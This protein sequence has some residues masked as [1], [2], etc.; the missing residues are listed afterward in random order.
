MWLNVNRLLVMTICALAAFSSIQSRALYDRG[1][2]G[3]RSS[4]ALA[5]AHC[6]ASHEIGKL[7]LAVN[8]NGTFATGFTEATL[9]D[10]FTGGQLRS[11]EFP[12]RS[13]TTYCFAAAFWIGAVIGRDTLVSQGADGWL[14]GQEFRPDESPIGDM[15]KRS[16]IDPTKKEFDGAISEED[17]ISVYTDT[18]LQGVVNDPVRG[19]HKPLF[20]EVTERSFAWSYSYAEDL[21]LFDFS[22]KNIGI[23]KIEDA[24]MGIY[25]DADVFHSTK[26]LDG[27]TDD[28]CGFKEVFPQTIG[29]CDYFDTVNLAWIADNNGDPTAGAFDDQ[30][31]PAVTA[32]RIVRTPSK[33]LDVSF[34]W[35]ISNGAPDLD[36]G[37]REQPG[38][39][40]LKEQF[41]DIG[42]GG[43]GT[44]NGDVNKYYFLRNREFDYDQIYT[45]SILPSDTLWMLPDQEQ[46]PDFTDGYDTRYLLSFGP[47]DID[48]GQDLPISLAYVAGEKFHRNPNNLANLP[49]NP[50]LFYSYLD[51]TD[52]AY[53]A[54]WASW[55][56]DTPGLDT[57][58]DSYKGDYLICVND[59]V[60]NPDSSITI[61]DADTL[62]I[63]GDGVPDFQGASP[64]PAPTLRLIAERGQITV[65]FNGL[66]SETTRDV[67]SNKFDFEG[68]RVHYARD[69][70][71]ASYS[72]LSSYDL[73][74][75]N[76]YV[77]SDQ[78]G[79]FVLLDVPFTLDAL[80]DLYGD[81][82]AP[83]EY[84]R[85][86]PYV[87]PLHA[88]SI[89]YF[90][91]QDFNSSDYRN[92]NAIHKVWPDQP[93]PSSLI[94]DSADSTELTPEG[95]L[96]YFEYEFVIK[97]LLESVPYWVN[98]TA[99]DYGSPVSGL[100]SLETSR[101]VGAKIAF[102]QRS[103]AD[104]NANKPPVYV[105]PNP[106]RG[107][108]NYN[109][110]G[111]EG[112]ASDKAEDYA[113]VINFANVPTKCTIR[114]YTLDGDLVKEIKHDKAIDDPTATHAEWNLITRN[115]QLV[116]SG[117]YYF[118]VE[119]VDGSV[120]IGKLTVIF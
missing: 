16:T 111:F 115:T 56:Y 40:R 34:N 93:Y 12:K 65:R 48:P 55:I 117:L 81:D 66:R 73:D 91:P 86:N 7:V 6:A 5:P 28:I 21:V 62:Y 78:L 79:D 33:T 3:G 19:P 92:P 98:V 64:P 109:A 68:Y 59:S 82:F 102:A 99:F 15:V 30:S 52:L 84:G 94:P 110:A 103:G 31:V 67:F 42:T 38:K 23:R 29:K 36:F 17:Y 108:A 32:T 58:G 80:H 120:Q 53:N 90:A 118:T 104:V 75:Y 41:R 107:D 71:S 8:N 11:C 54:R 95:D 14:P 61:L 60:I 97:N 105:Y 2:K 45:S 39:G 9:S 35:W 20:I 116:V 50:D 70:Q 85:D 47:F 46:G 88:D 113:R 89:F 43:I 37:P 74:D 119:A 69:E 63:R 4:M 18:L 49:N 25:V 101:T 13:S 24:Y 1:D 44:P 106:Y 57:D 72:T 51:F 87:L 100:P 76:K 27:Y 22:I 10:C 83:L 77:F 112:R 96:K 114:I 26:N